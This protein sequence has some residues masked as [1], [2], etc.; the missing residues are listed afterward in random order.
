[1][2]TVML[3]M[4]PGGEV[5]SVGP[6][7]PLRNAWPT[8]HRVPI[9]MAS[10]GGGGESGSTWVRAMGGVV[11][12]GV[13]DAV[14]DAVV[15]V[16]GV[17][18]MVADVDGEAVAVADLD[19]V[20][21]VVTDVDG[22]AVAVVDMEG[23][24]DGEDEAVG[25]TVLDGVLLGVCV[26]VTVGDGVQ[27]AERLPV[28]VM[29]GLGVVVLDGVRLGVGQDTVVVSDIMVFMRRITLFPTSL[30]ISS[31]TSVRAAP[32]VSAHNEADPPMLLT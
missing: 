13:S 15:D 8:N 22:D 18:V 12:D 32:T 4:T 16:D 20:A 24:T 3:V 11:G 5:D 23:V 26:L 1:L 19:G 28:P 29:D 25:V 9:A 31:P 7:P 30:V 10:D 14:G 2:T 6:A 27:V 21:V 17:A